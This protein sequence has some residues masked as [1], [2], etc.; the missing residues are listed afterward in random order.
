VSVGAPLTLF[1][2]QRSS[3]HDAFVKLVGQAP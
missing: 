1:E 3:L 2:P